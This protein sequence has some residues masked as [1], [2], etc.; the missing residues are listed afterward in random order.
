MQHQQS[1][2]LWYPRCRF[3]RPTSWQ[4]LFVA[5]AVYCVMSVQTCQHK[6]NTIK[7]IKF[8]FSTPLSADPSHSHTN[9]PTTNTQRYIK[10]ST[11]PP[12]DPSHSHT[13]CPTTNTQRYIQFS[14]PLPADPL[15]LQHKLSNYQ[16]TAIHTIQYATP[17][18]TLTLTHKMSNYQHTAVH[19]IQYDTPCLPPHTPTQNVQL[20]THSST[21]YSVCHSILT[22]SHSHIKCPITN[23]QQYI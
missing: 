7:K 21:Y 11:P 13:K 5:T 6:T 10:F 18:W 14:T 1:Q 17:C 3:L 4:P 19:T 23:T 22:P 20:P 9:C 16:H 8:I 2:L 15:T 12:A